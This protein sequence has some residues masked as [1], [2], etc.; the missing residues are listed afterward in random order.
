[1]T[2]VLQVGLALAGIAGLLLLFVGV[3]YGVGW[4]VGLGLRYAPLVGRRH[5]KGPLVGRQ[6]IETESSKHWSQRRP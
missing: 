5:R 2:T 3:A 4:L 6:P 1:M